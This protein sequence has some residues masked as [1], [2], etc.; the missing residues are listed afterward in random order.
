MTEGRLLDSRYELR[1]VVGAGGMAEVWRGVDHR[2]GRVVAVK[3]L[4][5]EL[6]RDEELQTR[7]RREAQ[8]VAALNH[9]SIVAV[10]D[11][12]VE[13]RGGLSIPFMV[14]EFV[15]GQTLRQILGEQGP[16]RADQAQKMTAQVLRALA[17]SHR[18]G[19]VHRDIKPGNI[20]LTPSGEVKVM[21]FGIARA[22][23][24]DQSSLTGT[25]AVVGT[26]QYLS[27]EQARGWAV[28]AR[29]DVYSTGCLLYELLAGRPPFVGDSPIAVA[30]QHVYDEPAPPSAFNPQV[31]LADAAVVMRALEKDPG[32]R[33]QTA[34]EMETAIWRVLS[35]APSPSQPSSEGQPSEGPG[36]S[37]ARASPTT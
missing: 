17:Y 1:E 21:D 30:C 19:I 15:R 22:L 29:S 2:L 26:A 36:A 12:G 16:V 24:A 31:P 20:M 5:A 25:S 4:R 3:V 35:G 6:A 7:F 28:D 23:A 11:T 18:C 37:Q 13:S 27:P 34:D 10:Y 14:M 33:Y 32:S 9:P 8:S